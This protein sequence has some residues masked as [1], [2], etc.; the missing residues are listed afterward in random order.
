MARGP[1]R[2][3]P[4]T[5]VMGV[6]SV[7][8]TIAMLVG[9]IVVLWRTR[10]ITQEVTS[11]TWLMAA[12]IASL[13]II[14]TASVWFSVFLVREIREGRRQITFIDSVTHELR[15]P[16]ASLKLGLETLGRAELSAAQREQIR[17]MM[18]A[19]VDRLS[20]FIEDI[21]VASR[22]ATSRFALRREHLQNIQN[23]AVRSL[24]LR[25]VDVIA[26]RHH[27]SADAFVVD[28]SPRLQ[29]HT[30]GT[31]LET[32]LKNLLDNAVKYSQPPP[33]VEVH[34][35]VTDNKFVLEVS[36]QGIG[37]PSQHLKRIFER[38]YRVP[39]EAVRSRRGTGLG[40]FVV[41]GLVRNLGGKLDVHSPGA[42]RGTR[43]RIILPANTLTELLPEEAS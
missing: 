6:I 27:I 30:D 12:G 1:L 10:A 5:I 25:C 2:S 13:V 35:Q 29:L 15:S 21:L 8:L 38:F 24:V 14:M 3:V 34:A 39:G 41:S 18:R 26:R 36:D 32:A 31:A 40:L 42:G 37:I 7:L 28:V 9:W 11:N 20:L 16:L 17:D 33:R 23:V 4:L 19:D 22:V 43:M